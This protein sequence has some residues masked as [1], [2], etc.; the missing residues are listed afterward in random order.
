[1]V[2][3]I[4]STEV[5]GENQYRACR[6][7]LADEGIAQFVFGVLA[8]GIGLNRV[9]DLEIRRCSRSGDVYVCGRIGND[10]ATVVIAVTAAEKREITEY[11]IDNK[12]GFGIVWT[13]SETNGVCRQDSKLSIDFSPDSADL[14]IDDRF[15]LEDFTAAG[16]KNEIPL[17]VQTDVICPI[18][19]QRDGLWIAAAFYP[20]VIFKPRL[21]SVIDKINARVD[22]FI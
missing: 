5:R 8:S 1:C 18:K 2:V 4:S 19:C 11:R 3:I 14:L 21:V 9:H 10:S 12:N 7:Q 16:A 17:R 22:A 20:E 6:I 15:V 13:D